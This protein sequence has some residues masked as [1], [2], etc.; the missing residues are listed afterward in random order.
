M[1]QTNVDIVRE[2][3][4]AYARRDA[5]SPRHLFAED[6]RFHNRAEFPGRESF[7]LDEIRTLWAD[8]DETFTD[9][10][11]A[12]TD[13]TDGAEAV[14]VTLQASTRLKGSH[15]RLEGTIYHVWR[16]SDGLIRSAH[17]YSDREEALAA[18]GLS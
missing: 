6:F 2:I 11:L 13:M 10:E 1:A 7:G 12:P 8:L 17:T 4:A 18:A 5:D 3:Y 14:L 15:A 16:I 9:Y